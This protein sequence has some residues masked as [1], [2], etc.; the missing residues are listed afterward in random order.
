MGQA[1]ER[2]WDKPALG[3]SL[4][5]RLGQA[6]AWDKPALV[7][8]TDRLYEFERGRSKE[9]SSKGLASP[10]MYR[11]VIYVVIAYCIVQ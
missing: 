11:I 10:Y 5:A 9:E 6:R 3:T 1:L 4:S 2:S 8:S 7:L